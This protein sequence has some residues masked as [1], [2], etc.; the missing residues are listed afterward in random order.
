MNRACLFALVALTIVACS[1]PSRRERCER[2]ADHLGKISTATMDSSSRARVVASCATWPESVLDCLLAAKS[3]REIS[4]CE[5][6][7]ERAR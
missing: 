2:A 5:S 3:D 7:L 6:Q 4:S 1:K